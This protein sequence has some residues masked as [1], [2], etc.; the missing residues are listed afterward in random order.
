MSS[1]AS[2]LRGWLRITK[3]GTYPDVQEIL[4]EKTLS[5]ARVLTFSQSL[6]LNFKLPHAVMME[7]ELACR[8]VSQRVRVEVCMKIGVGGRNLMLLS[9]RSAQICS[10][11]TNQTQEAR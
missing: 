10:R 1:L 9:G 6:C 4:T 3:Q 8:K 5:P 7:P 2:S 11:W